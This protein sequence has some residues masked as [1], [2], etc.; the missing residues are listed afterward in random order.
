[1][2]LVVT[3]RTDKLEVL[4]FIMRPIS[5]FVMHVQN[6]FFVIPAPLA[7]A[8][9]LR[10]QTQLYRSL[11]HNLISQS[12][13]LIPNTSPIFIGAA[14][15]AGLLVRACKNRLLTN[16][17]RARFSLHEP[18]AGLAAERSTLACPEFAR[19]TIDGRFTD[20]AMNVRCSLIGFHLSILSIS[21][22]ALRTAP[23]HL[24]RNYS[25]FDS[26]FA[27]AGSA[28]EGARAGIEAANFLRNGKSSSE[29]SL[30]ASFANQAR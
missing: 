22:H 16:Q 2:L 5:I 30:L 23:T 26:V 1:M 15:A 10:K 3:I 9:A 7:Y 20:E 13:D 14:P 21:P 29:F 12:T 27:G 4:K 8:V 11:I 19:P 28:C 25:G 18:V 17:T 24:L 6:F